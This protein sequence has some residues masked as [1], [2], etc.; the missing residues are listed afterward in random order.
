MAARLADRPWPGAAGLD[1]EVAY[2]RPLWTAASKP[3]KPSIC[4]LTMI[5]RILASKFPS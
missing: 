2:I 1:V 3:S 5:V 4:Q